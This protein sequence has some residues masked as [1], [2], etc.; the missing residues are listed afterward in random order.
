MH[1]NI[2][3]QKLHLCAAVAPTC[4]VSHMRTRILMS[5]KNVTCS[6]CSRKYLKGYAK[7]AQE[8]WNTWKK[9]YDTCRMA[10][11]NVRHF[12]FHGCCVAFQ[13]QVLQ[14]CHDRHCRCWAFEKHRHVD[15]SICEECKSF[16]CINFH[17]FPFVYKVTRALWSLLTMMPWHVRVYTLLLWTECFI[18]VCEQQGCWLQCMHTYCITLL[19]LMSTLACVCSLNECVY[20]WK[21]WI[22]LCF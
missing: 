3:Y 21:S 17:Y 11:M 2:H 18:I 5:T 19:N 8:Y 4:S 9:T 20:W 13:D 7:T 10:L 22:S 6:Y 15:I 1:T 14:A 12:I 16:V